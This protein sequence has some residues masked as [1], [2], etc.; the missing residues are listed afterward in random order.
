M[1]TFK[2]LYSETGTPNAPIR[3]LISMMVLK[4]EEGLS[5]EKLF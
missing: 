3:V 2:P 4:E 5:D 1:K